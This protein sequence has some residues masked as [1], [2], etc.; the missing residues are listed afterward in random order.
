MAGASRPAHD[1]GPGQPTLPGPMGAGNEALANI[2]TEIE[3]GLGGVPLRAHSGRP[4]SR[5]AGPRPRSSRRLPGSTPNI[6]SEFRR[7]HEP[8]PSWSTRRAVPLVVFPPRRVVVF[9]LTHPVGLRSPDHVRVRF[10]NPLSS[11]PAWAPGGHNFHKS[12]PQ[13]AMSSRIGA[14]HFPDRS[15]NM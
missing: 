12:R 9:L 13:R 4:K 8:D 3:D 7:I 2:V 11:R 6:V 15:S 5:G 10:G 14:S 1:R